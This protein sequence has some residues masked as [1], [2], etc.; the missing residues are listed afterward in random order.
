MLPE[1][2]FVQRWENVEYY[3]KEFKEGTPEIYTLKGERVRSKSEMMIADALNKRGIP[4]RYEYPIFIKGYGWFYPDFTTLKL[5]N[6]KEKIWEHFG[7]MDEPE[8][9]DNAIRKIN[10][11]EQNGIFLGENLIVTF[12]TK[13]HP[14]SQREIER[15]IQ[16]HY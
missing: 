15:I 14:L 8:Y 10:G 16:H 13:N 3:G 7:L 1:E 4:Y 2:E 9:V 6:R 11:Y 5:R 12:E